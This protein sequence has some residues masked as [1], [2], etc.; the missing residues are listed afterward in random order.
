MS[1]TASMKT[2]S[3][4]KLASVVVIMKGLKRGHD[5]DR[6]IGRLATNVFDG[7]EN[8][9]RSYYRYVARSGFVPGFESS[10]PLGP[11]KVARRKLVIVQ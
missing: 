11:R 4:T 5:Y 10:S 7:D 1:K 6:A 2:K 3:S 8:V 9:A